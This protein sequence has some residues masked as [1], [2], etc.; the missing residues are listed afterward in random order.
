MSVAR[1]TNVPTFDDL[2]EEIRDFINATG[3]WSIHEDLTAADEGVA[4][5]GRRLVASNGDCL[6]G[7]RSTTTGAGANHLYLFDGIPPWGGSVNND[8]LPGNS[9]IRMTDAN[10]N[11][12]SPSGRT[13][14][15]AFAGPFPTVFLFTDDPS[16]YLHAAIEVT[17]GKFRHLCFGNM[18]KFGT[19]TGGA[20]YASQ[21]WDTSASFIDQPGS[22]AHTVPFD[23]GSSGEHMWTMYYQS[24]LGN[25]RCPSAETRNGTVRSL[26][27]GSVRGGFGHAFRNIQETP[28]SGFIALT[29]ITMWTIAT[30]DAPDTTRCIGQIKDMAEVNMRNLE[31][32]ESYFIGSDEWIVFPI[33]S[34]RDPSVSDDLENG[35]YY[36][37]AYL[38]KP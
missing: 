3:D 22:N 37:F 7:L 11:T 23:S 38:V 20:Y 4:S 2:L 14:N 27:K 33:S 24:G 6:V 16:T 18:K 30:A 19:W 29:P 31:P 25:W 9:G 12:A 26:A 28:F 15:G 17:A 10:Y 5:G 21:Y 8:V 13:H 35:G 34:K 36:G 1:L 32:G